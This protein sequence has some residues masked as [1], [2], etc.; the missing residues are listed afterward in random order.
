MVNYATLFRRVRDE[1]TSARET[2]QSVRSGKQGVVFTFRR[3]V[4]VNW[5]LDE[6]LML[7]RM[8]KV[9]V[10]KNEI[11]FGSQAR[12]LVLPLE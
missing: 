8:V 9:R 5:C 11:L 4:D 3:G 12:Q 10:R 6:V 2:I 1:N 7:A